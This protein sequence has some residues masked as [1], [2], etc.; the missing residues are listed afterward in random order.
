MST[1]AR[2][3]KVE[4]T[5]I[6]RTN[7]AGA[8]AILAA[9]IGCLMVAGLAILGDKSAAMGSFFVFV[10]PTGPLSGVTTCAI[11]VWLACW[12]LLHARWR[13]RTVALGRVGA[14]AITLL[15]LGVLLTFPPIA[16][17]F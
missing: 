12:A 1:Q 6:E 13:G 4:E 14:A 5:A 16:D 8:A 7:G 15:I 3:S 11:A 9:G 10:K 2:L 17:L